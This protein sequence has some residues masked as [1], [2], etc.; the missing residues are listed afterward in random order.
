LNSS[1]NTLT[2]DIPLIQ[3]SIQVMTCAKFRIMNSPGDQELIYQ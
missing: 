3:R 1:C 2:F